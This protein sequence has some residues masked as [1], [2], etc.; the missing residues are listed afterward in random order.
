MKKCIKRFFRERKQNSLLGQK[1]R[2]QSKLMMFGLMIFAFTMTMVMLSDAAPIQKV[3]TL[4]I[5][6]M[7]GIDL[8]L[9]AKKVEEMTEDE[10]VIFGTIQKQ[11]NDA[12]AAAMQG[13]IGGE[14]IDLRLKKLKEDVEQRISN[15]DNDENKKLEKKFNEAIELIEDCRKTIGT[16]STEVA[17]YKQKNSGFNFEDSEIVKSFKSA[18]ETERFRSFVSGTGGKNSG[19]FEINLK[20]NNLIKKGIVSF[21]NNVTGTV[22][23]AFQSD[24]VVNEVQLRK[25]NLRD[26]MTVTDVSMEEFTSYHFMIIYD[27]DRAAVALSEN[28]SLPE[29]SFK[30]KEG[31][32]ETHRIGWHLPISKRMLRK[33]KVL[34]QR[35]IQLLPSGM[36][37]SEN[38]Q[39]LYGDKTNPNFVGITQVCKNENALTGKVYEITETGSVIKIEGYNNNTETKV[40]FAKGFAKIQTGMK[41]VFSGF[42]TAVGLNS[43]NGFECI[44]VNDHTII[45]PCAYTAETDD[46]VKA[47]VKFTVF[48][49]W[50]K[51]IVNANEGD[52][53]R[54]LVS[55]LNF[56]QYMPNFIGMNPITLCT[57]MSMKDANGRNMAS[58]YIKVV[59]KIPY[60]DG[61]IP[62]V[63]LDCI[64]KGKV[65]IG[66]F[67]N[68]CELFDTQ[69]GYLEFAED[70]NTKLTNQI[71][72]IIQE[73]VIFAIT[74]PD[75]FIYADLANTKQIINADSTLVTNVNIVGPLSAAGAVKMDAQ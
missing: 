49:I 33:L 41:V 20:Q 40:T 70:V 13:V 53:I 43:A 64:P 45:I 50:G 14:E 51:F 71:V 10:K 69:K 2:F 8:T 75:A 31:S 46:S 42:Q 22:L 44:V 16:L 4:A 36:Y 48:N 23:P 30:T 47:N 5:V 68:A 66:D 56:D 19:Q 3:A 63:E 57:L 12:V 62:I 38:F 54:A 1:R 55:F 21:E 6:P 61:L 29:G 15:P 59:N 32:A 11:L 73:E 52:A 18:F 27:I 35:I 74:C 72:S 58:E 34:M 28:G 25:L 24:V 17:E 60:L 67:L 65:I 39:I 9:K 26:F 7:A 37:R